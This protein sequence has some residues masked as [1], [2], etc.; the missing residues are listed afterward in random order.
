MADIISLTG[1]LGSG[2]STVSSILCERLKYD[3]IYTG[4]IQRKIAF[5]YG[6]TTT[7]LNKYAETHPE[8]DDEIDSTFK[9]LNNS[10]RLIVDSRLAWFFI[11]DSFKVFMKTN[12]FISS[13]R[14]SGD[15]KRINENYASKEEAAHNIIARKTSENKRYAELYGANCSDL[16]N[17][18]LII[19]TS[20][21]RPEKVAEVIITEFDLWKASLQ[22]KTVSFISPE[23]LYPTISHRDLSNDRYSVVLDSMKNNGYDSDNPVTVVN[24]N[25]FDYI[26]DSDGHILTSCA[27]KNNIDLIPVTYK[28]EAINPIISSM[29]HEWENFN[30]FKF[31]IYPDVNS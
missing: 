9:S 31:L 14:I 12:L 28:D 8:I 22:R 5:R 3:Y 1:D 26:F 27:I 21:I 15:K 6:M 10:E 11:P 19:D 2:K 23:N 20:F 25:S 30:S 7:E 24:I 16:N 18:N 4:E 17:F 29:F 13:E